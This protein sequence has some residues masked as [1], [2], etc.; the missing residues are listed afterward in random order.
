MEIRFV[1]DHDSLT[2]RH[3]R[4]ILEPLDKGAGAV[5]GNALRRVLL[6]QL[7]GAAV[8]AVKF[9]G[10]SHEYA[11]IPGAVEDTLEV[12]RNLKSLE[13]RVSRPGLKNLATARAA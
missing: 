2:N 7:S 1:C 6:S 3:G 8:T 12:I 11:P 10:V 13:V 4:F 5:I 9:Q